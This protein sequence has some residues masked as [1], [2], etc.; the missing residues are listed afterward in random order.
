[1]SNAALLIMTTGHISET[2]SHIDR[3]M[4]YLGHLERRGVFAAP[5]SMADVQLENTAKRLHEIASKLE[6]LRAALRANE[7]RIMQAAE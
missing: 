1:M 3:S 5:G 6:R 2:A 7:P 4:S